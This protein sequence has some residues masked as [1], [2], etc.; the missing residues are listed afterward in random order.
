MMLHNFEA[1]PLQTTDATAVPWRQTAYRAVAEGFDVVLYNWRARGVSEGR[2]ARDG[3]EC[4][5]DI[6][7]LL[8]AFEAGCLTLLPG[9]TE[10]VVWQLIP[11]AESQSVV[12]FGYG[13][14]SSWVSNAMTINFAPSFNGEANT[15]FNLRGA[16]L[17]WSNGGSLYYRSSL[18]P[19]HL[20]NAALM[21]YKFQSTPE[22]D[23]S[24]LEHVGLWPGVLLIYGTEDRSYALAG[25]VEMYN[26]ARGFKGIRTVIGEALLAPEELPGT[27]SASLKFARRIVQ[28]EPDM[29]NKATTTVVKQVCKALAYDY[30]EE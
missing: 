29:D 9:E 23:S 24:V 17:I 5:R 12:L 8:E 3:A 28:E 25:P 6:F 30:E 22:T 19:F 14:G 16:I 21:R 7:R 2:N 1:T 20:M 27:I 18:G 26:R 15:L 10:P 4:G 13:D 11:D